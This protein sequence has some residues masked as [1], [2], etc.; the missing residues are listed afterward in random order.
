MRRWLA[1]NYLAFSRAATLWSRQEGLNQVP[2]HGGADGSAARA[3]PQAVFT[4][5][6]PIFCALCAFMFL[7]T[8]VMQM[9]R[10]LDQ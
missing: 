8:V 2:G 7:K 10:Q 4:L 9:P 3:R 6:I 5:P 1:L